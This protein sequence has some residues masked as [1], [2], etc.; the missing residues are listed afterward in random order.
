[1][2]R[3]QFLCAAILLTGA[4]AG[5]QS[6]WHVD[7]TNPNAPGDGSPGNPY[8]SI[9]FAIAA[10]TTLT[11]DT[12]SVHPG[13]YFEAIDL[14][15]KG[16]A[17]GGSA[18]PG[19]TILDGSQSG[20]SVVSVKSGEPEG[21][22]LQNLTIRQG[23][24]TFLPQFDQARGGGIYCKD[25]RLR[26][27]DCI[28]TANSTVHPGTGLAR[29]AGGAI[30]AENVSSLLLIDC[31]ISNN[32]ATQG[33]GIWLEQSTAAIFFSELIGNHALATNNSFLIQAGVAGGLGAQ[34]SN[35]NVDSTQVINNVA[36]AIQGGSNTP[37]RGGGVVIWGG[38]ASI[39]NSL[40]QANVAG[41]PGVLEYPGQGGALEVLFTSQPQDVFI[42][43]CQLRTNIARNVGG[44]VFGTCKLF[45]CEITNNQAQHG[46][47]LYAAGGM[48]VDQC[49]IHDNVPTT[50]ADNAGVGIFSFDSTSTLV[51]D[52]KIHGHEA[53]GVG[54]GVSGGTY[55]NCDIYDNKSIGP[56]ATGGGGA[57]QA[58]LKGCRVF[59]NAAVETGSASPSSLGGGLLYCI[60][61]RTLVF[62]NQANLGAG[63]YECELVHCSVEGNS[64]VGPGTGG[65][66]VRGSA[67]NSILWNNT[68]DDVA[69]A[70]GT[71]FVTWSDIGTGWPGVGNISLDPQFWMPTLN[72][73]FLRPNSPCIDA[74][75]PA[76]PSDPDGSRAD[77]GAIP[78]YPSHYAQPVPYC[79][80]KVNSAGCLPAIAS[81]GP[82]SVCCGGL[83]TVSATQVLNQK[84]GLLF[85]GRQP[86]STPFQG[87]T[88]CVEPPLVRTQIQNSN[89]S[90]SG[91]D[92]TGS[93]VFHWSSSYLAQEGL[94]P[95]DRVFAQFWS[96]DPDTSITVG[97][98]NA[99]DI[100]FIP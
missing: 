14:L 68:P 62:D 17:I 55:T 100:T 83:L 25:S 34:N 45:D 27:Q 43:N 40:F 97:L 35:L 12:I 18:G 24:G 1:M 96:R 42:A 30:Y 51:T 63:A 80:A 15:G 53:I 13:T 11:G 89:G 84:N 61:E 39:L 91:T 6:L 22:T 82:P 54:I 74:A 75:N 44:G 93:Y 94:L 10:P 41:V 8:T 78:F 21:T 2:L 32:R 57:A 65:G 66:L 59:G 73:Y 72:D 23:K 3:T 87:G 9:Q 71:T 16:L 81:S 28:V 36:F 26:L 5:A 33:G 76:S 47:G 37:A 92:C 58:V 38:T 31:T 52:T 99:L 67:T 69:A 49:D 4:S 48:L 77:M 29:G 56:Y 85:W 79:T 7:K 98:T 90:T 19:L 60:A 64:V 20:T 95:G 46:A 86:S 88:L 70:D 50:T